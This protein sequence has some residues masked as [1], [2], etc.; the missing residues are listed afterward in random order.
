MQLALGDKELRNRLREL[1]VKD[2]AFADWHIQAPE[3]PALEKTGVLVIDA[4]ALKALPL[5]LPHPER[6]VLVTRRTAE[7]L[8]RAWEAGIVSV[9][10]DHEPLGTIMLA[11]LAARYRSCISPV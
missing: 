10:F 3:R 1:I 5:P 4:D 7:E 6:V 8:T 9:V 11:I 2:P